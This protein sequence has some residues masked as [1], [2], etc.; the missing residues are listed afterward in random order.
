MRVARLFVAVASALLALESLAAASQETARF[1]FSLGAAGHPLSGRIYDGERLTDALSYEG[2][3]DGGPSLESLLGHRIACRGIVVLGEMHDNPDHHSWRAWLLE[4]V[5]AKDG[6]GARCGPANR[7]VG[8]VAAVLEQIR[9]DQRAALDRFN[10]MGRNKGQ[11][12][13]VDDLKRQLDWGSSGWSKYAYE[14]LLEAFI[15]GGY[16]LYPGDPARETIK[17]VARE[18]A[19]ALP[20][21]ELKRLGLDAPLGA[22]LDRASLQEIE[23]AH[24]GLLPA[25]MMPSMAFAQ[26]Y[27]DAHLADATLGAA[28][29][30]G[31]A[32]LITGNIHARR[33]RGVPWY[34]RQRAPEVKLKTVLLVEVEE[35]KEDPADYMP[36]DP[37]G[38]P[39]ADYL[40]FTAAAPHDDP[41]ARMRQ[42]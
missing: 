39:A 21:D 18:G 25:E 34:V 38:Q 12:V 17:R 26:R 14:P 8:P 23:E 5:V 22:A 1:Q 28:R 11:A 19:S 9:A 3:S 15:R 37:D 40:V 42:K 2:P 31:A 16:P 13:N 27:R 20:P 35:G 30:H 7:T 41:C 10:E 29:D 6:D 36:R 4:A 32:V 33:D 24:C